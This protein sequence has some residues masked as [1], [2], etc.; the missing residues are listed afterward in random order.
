MRVFTIKLW[1]GYAIIEHKREVLNGLISH[2]CSTDAEEVG[3]LLIVN[4]SDRQ[5]ELESRFLL[6]L[7]RPRLTHPEGCPS[8]RTESRLL[9]MILNWDL[10]LL[11]SW[12]LV[13][14]VDESSFFLAKSCKE[15]S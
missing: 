10:L 3:K 12:P 15:A 5:L 11:D 1:V 8:E 14:A 7:A 4:A 9:W 2:F 13:A 6:L